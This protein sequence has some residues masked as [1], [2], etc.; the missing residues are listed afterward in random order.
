[1][2]RALSAISISVKVVTAKLFIARLDRQIVGR[3]TRNE[4]LKPLS[5]AHI[6]VDKVQ[7]L[8][9]AAKVV[10]PNITVKLL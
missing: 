1:M 8:V 3:W 9:L 6:G 4:Q 10:N 7:M 2:V 5:T